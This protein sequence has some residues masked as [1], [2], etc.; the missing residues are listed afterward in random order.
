MERDLLHQCSDNGRSSLLLELLSSARSGREDG[1]TAAQTDAVD[2]VMTSG[3]RRRTLA[4]I[5]DCADG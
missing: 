1:H 2:S 4:A 3:N 5:E